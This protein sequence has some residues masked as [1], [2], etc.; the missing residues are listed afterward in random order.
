[1]GPVNDSPLVRRCWI[2]RSGAGTSRPA[3][4][5]VAKAALG[6]GS[7]RWKSGASPRDPGFQPLPIECAWPGQGRVAVRVSVARAPRAVLRE[8][9]KLGLLKAGGGW[10]E[11]GEMLGVSGPRL[12]AAAPL[13]VLRTRSFLSLTPTMREGLD[14]EA[15]SRLSVSSAR[16]SAR[17]GDVPHLST[18]AIL[19]PT[20]TPARP[21][22]SCAEN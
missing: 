21:F 2:P 5:L 10:L 20:H 8:W 19:P 1:M 6:A 22:L 15:P 12:E 14:W 13:S 17:S 3:P 7:W 9:E 16:T 11:P 4:T 18:R